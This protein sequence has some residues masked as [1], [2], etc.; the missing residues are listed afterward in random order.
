MHS[1]IDA[2]VERLWLKW[3]SGAAGLGA[4][5]AAGADA[6]MTQESLALDRRRLRMKAAGALFPAA[7]EAA[8]ASVGRCIG[9]AEWALP[10]AAAAEEL[11]WARTG[12]PYSLVLCAPPGRGKSWLATWVVAESLD[13][14][15]WMQASDCRVGDA[16]SALREKALRMGLLV[17]DDLGEEA[18]GDWGVREMATLLESRHNSGRRTVVTTNL[19]PVEIGKRYGE[20]LLSRWSETAYSRMVAVRGDDL[21]RGRTG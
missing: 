9:V 17:V 19:A 10:M 20:R 2:A 8:M 11:A 4:S 3:R 7:V 15:L 21:R 1:S 16:W 6:E 5:G 12:P 13:R 18:S 14:A